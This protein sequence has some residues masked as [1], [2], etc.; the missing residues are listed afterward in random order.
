M[1]TRITCIA[2]AWVAL[3]AAPAQAQYTGPRQIQPTD[4]AVWGELGFFAGSDR[5]GTTD[6]DTTFF[7]TLLR[8]YIGVGSLELPFAWGF[9]FTSFDAGGADDSAFRFGNPFAGLNFKLEK[10]DFVL[11]IGG[12]V[13]LPVATVDD[14][15][16][17]DEALTQVFALQGAAAIVG[18]WDTWLWAPDRFTIVAPSFR[19]DGRGGDFVW[20]AEAALGVLIDTSD[21]DRDAEVAIQAAV[22]GGARLGRMFVLGGRFQTVLWATPEDDEDLTQLAFVPFVRL[23]GESG[24][25]YLRMTINLDEPYGFAFDDRGIWGLHAGGGARF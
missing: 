19:M 14:D 3:A 4:S 11:R 5:I 9:A 20:A 16:S 12:G 21:A 18:L 15:A 10:R 24:F 6:V 25:G 8:A 22:E 7:R 17:L 2:A 13:A 23:E 1:L